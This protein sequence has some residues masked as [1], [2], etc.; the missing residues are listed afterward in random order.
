MN[1]RGQAV[2]HTGTLVGIE[3]VPVE[4]QVDVSSGLPCFQVVGLGDAAVLEAR[5]R[6]RSALRSAGFEFPSARIVV[7][8][9]PAPLRKHGT[10]FDLPVAVGVLTATGQIPQRSSCGRYIV[11]ELALDGGVR[12]LAGLLAHAKAARQRELVLVGPVEVS[13]YADALPGLDADPLESLGDIRTSSRASVPVGRM[14]PMGPPQPDLAD[15]VGLE[16]AVRVITI[17]AAGGHNVL[18]VGPP[19]SGKSMLARRLPA[20]LP[21]LDADERLETAL[22][23]SVAGLDESVPLSGC[24][25]FRSPH[26][27]CT[28]AGLIGGGTPARPGEASLAHNGVLFLDEIPEF[29]PAALQTLRQPLEDGLVTLVRA[30]GRVR[31]PARF[32]LV[33]AANPCPCGFFGDSQRACTC[34]PAVIARYAAR[35]GGP[36]MDR[37]DVALRVDRVDPSAI[38]GGTGTVSTETAAPMV[39]AA[40]EFAR[41]RGAQPP[42]RLAGRDL[43]EACRL[44]GATAERLAESA[45]RR[46]LSGRGVTRVLRVAR[47]IA[48]LEE[49]PSVQYGHLAEAIAYRAWDLGTV[50][51]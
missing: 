27:S 18:L 34:P 29:G 13:H 26:H 36:L 49:S 51:A 44:T 22:L 38:L 9:A 12:S 21:P 3:S 45:R 47:T 40:R 17:A 31:Y 20:L 2:I 28:T 7:N 6:V 24:R 43:L 35:I 42:S 30:E 33:A 10:G 25:P 16:C 8:L 15:V 32:A 11:G 37:M 41:S 23:H 48:D 4:V 50:P 14:S 39:L 5:E 1:P 46:C 19:G